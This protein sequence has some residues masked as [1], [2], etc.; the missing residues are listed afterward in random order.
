MA[1]TYATHELVPTGSGAGR[2]VTVN[3]RGYV[4]PDL[5]SDWRA[6]LVVVNDSGVSRYSSL[7]SSG[8]NS[9]TLAA[10]ENKVYLTVA[11][12][13]GQYLIPS[14]SESEQPYISH[15]ARERYPYEIQ[16][17]GA[18]P[19]GSGTGGSTRRPLQRRRL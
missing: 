2:V 16:V 18:T 4:N 5:Q 9:V 1:Y 13:P 3:L 11:A 8:S 12:T 14:N 6:A 17:T 10:N 15:P 19:K 7:W